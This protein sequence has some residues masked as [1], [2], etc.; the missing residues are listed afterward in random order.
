MRVCH[1]VVRYSF[2]ESQQKFYCQRLVEMHIQLCLMRPARVNKRGQI[3]LHDNARPHVSRMKLQKLTDLG[4]ET[5]PHPPYSPDLSFTQLPFF[6]YLDT[7]NAK[8]N[9]S[10]PKG[11]SK[12]HSKI[13]WDQ[14]LRVLSYRYK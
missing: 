7:F 10:V 13:C 1:Y 2:L 6:K 5:L 9:V 8:R 11:K 4:Y 3:L 12:L 14:N